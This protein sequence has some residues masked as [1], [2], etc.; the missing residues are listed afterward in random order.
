MKTF[1]LRRKQVMDRNILYLLLLLFGDL[2]GLLRLPP[3]G[4][5]HGGLDVGPAVEVA[6]VVDVVVVVGVARAGCG[7][8]PDLFGRIRGGGGG[9]DGQGFRIVRVSLILITV[10]R[11]SSSGD[12]DGT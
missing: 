2:V 9:G 6:A 5:H 12:G 11:T 7:A 4:A 10:G 8:H 3:L 1:E